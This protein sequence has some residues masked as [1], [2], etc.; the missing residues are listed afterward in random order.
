VP[1]QWH[2][3]SGPHFG[4]MLSLLTF[5]GR[6]ARVRF[7]R[8]TTPEGDQDRGTGARLEVADELLLTDVAVT[9]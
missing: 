1:I 5:D 6:S 2:H 7:E 8:S 3:P 4:N 9:P